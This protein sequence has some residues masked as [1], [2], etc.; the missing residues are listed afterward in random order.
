MDIL[1]YL[2]KRQ[3][4]LEYKS[5]PVADQDERFKYLYCYGLGV[6]AVGNLKAVTELQPSFEAV[7]DSIYI[8]QKS[9]NQV[10]VDI[11]NSFDFRIAEF[12]KRINSKEAQYCF[13]ADIYKLYRLALWSQ[14]YCRGILG[15]YL[16]V[17]R[18]SDAECS[19]FEKFNKAA[20]EKNVEAAVKYYKEFK[21]EGY[22]IS[23]QILVYFFP[24][25]E[26]E[27]HYK[28]IHIEPGKTVVF[29]K[30]V[31]IDGDIT[32]ERGGSL[33]INGAFVSMKGSVST[34]G[35]R[36]R[37]KGA[38]VRVEEC[39]SGFWMDFKETAVVNI[40]DSFIDCG[41]ACG[42][43]R[44]EAGRLII[45]RSE[46][47]R[48]EGERAVSFNGLSSVIENTEFYSNVS[49]AIGIYGSAK[50]VLGQCSF[51]DASADYGGAVYSESIGN[52]KIERCNFNR[53]RAD[54]LGGAVYFKYQKFGQ[55]VKDC[56]CNACIPQDTCI[57]NVYDDDV[58]LKVR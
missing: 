50:M 41:K 52:V 54:Y 4:E 8:S 9:R 36:I 25:F 57:F 34:V 38:R 28:D 19:F 14:D 39:G 7:L 31:V 22:D 13:M 11:N 49:G 6:M 32:V 3:S 47:K 24:E 10:I 33:L 45:S 55:Y 30:P 48:T 16:K 42:F 15:N 53:C 12:F 21:N 44:Q 35:G 37:L 27:E 26:M 23:Y 51:N 29:D 43:L 17:F 1:E 46:I 20:Q 58:E 18:F 40:E 5:H 2:K 56:E